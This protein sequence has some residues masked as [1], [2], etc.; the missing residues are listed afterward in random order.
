MQY[1]HMIHMVMLHS[2]HIIKENLPIVKF[3]LLNVTIII[4]TVFEPT[5]ISRYDKD[6]VVRLESGGLVFRVN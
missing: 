6:V 3:L 5:T 4:F 1:I 2:D